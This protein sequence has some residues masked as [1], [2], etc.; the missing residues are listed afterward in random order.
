MGESCDSRRGMGFERS[1]QECDFG[2]CSNVHFL[3]FRIVG[4]DF[5]SGLILGDFMSSTAEDST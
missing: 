4:L 5:E 3:Q 1:F 2:C